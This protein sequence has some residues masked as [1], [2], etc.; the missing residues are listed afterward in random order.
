M[1]RAGNGPTSAR[2]SR[3]AYPSLGLLPGYTWLRL[4]G[5]FAFV[6]AAGRCVFLGC[7]F[8]LLSACYDRLIARAFKALRYFDDHRIRGMTTL[9]AKLA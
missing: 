7:P 8:S 2:L 5:R 6:V 9:L 3:P 1:D 4:L